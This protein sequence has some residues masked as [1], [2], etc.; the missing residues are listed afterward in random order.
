[1]KYYNRAHGI[2]SDE[3]LDIAIYGH[4]IAEVA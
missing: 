3:D 4:E 1:M 2:M